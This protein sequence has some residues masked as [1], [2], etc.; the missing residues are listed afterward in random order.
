MLSRITKDDI[1]R[2][3]KLWEENAD[4]PLKKLLKAKKK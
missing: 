2:A 1:K 3:G 4:R